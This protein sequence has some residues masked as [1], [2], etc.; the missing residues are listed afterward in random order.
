MR[1]KLRSVTREQEV[2]LGAVLE[3]TATFVVKTEPRYCDFGK[4][5]LMASS[6]VFNIAKYL[7]PDAT[8]IS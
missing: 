6:V 5:R 4:D 8:T 7:L 1:P 3:M 2:L